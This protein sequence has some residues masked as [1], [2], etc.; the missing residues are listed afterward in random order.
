MLFHQIGDDSAR[1]LGK[2]DPSLCVYDPVACIGPPP[3]QL[4]ANDRERHWQ[5]VLSSLR[6][7]DY[8]QRLLP[9]LDSNLRQTAIIPADTEPTTLPGSLSPSLHEPA[10]RIVLD[11]A[12]QH[13]LYKA[14]WV[15][16]HHESPPDETG[17]SGQQPDDEVNSPELASD[18]LQVSL[19]FHQIE[20][21][22]MC[23]Q[24]CVPW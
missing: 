12:R 13:E 4:V 19:E 11:T 23:I 5:Q 24:C 6:L 17:L 2:P 18:S 7:G 10:G 22:D 20:H 14:S 3:R 9:N 16:Q 21:L 15:A 8:H 1:S